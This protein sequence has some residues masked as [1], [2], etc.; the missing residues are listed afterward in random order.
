MLLAVAT[1]FLTV[2]IVIHLEYDCAKLAIEAVNAVHD[3]CKEWNAKMPT[4]MKSRMSYEVYAHSEQN[5]R[6]KMEDKHI[7]MT[8]VNNFYGLDKVMFNSPAACASLEI[9]ARK[10]AKCK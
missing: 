7:V 1:A 4:L 8:E 9:G 6:R 10:L 5:T 3:I 2:F